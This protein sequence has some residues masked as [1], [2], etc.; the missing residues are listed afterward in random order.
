MSF[1]MGTTV[2]YEKTMRH[3]TNKQKLVEKEMMKKHA[4][5]CVKAT[6]RCNIPRGIGVVP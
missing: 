1:R 3:C 5:T 4:T 6:I 2:I